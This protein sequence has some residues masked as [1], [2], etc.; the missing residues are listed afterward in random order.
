MD[1]RAIGDLNLILPHQPPNLLL[2]VTAQ[3]LTLPLAA[4][5]LDLHDF[6]ACNYL[7]EGVNVRGLD[8]LSVRE[9]QEGFGSQTV[10][11]GGGDGDVC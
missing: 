4:V 9:G 5:D 2:Q 11:T 10:Q 1:F 8:G 7:P 3:L 6:V